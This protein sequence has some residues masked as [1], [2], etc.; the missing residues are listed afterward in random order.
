MKM[1]ICGDLVPTATTEP[2]FIKGDREALFGSVLD[3]FSNADRV[4]VNLECALTDTNTPIPK[5]GPNLKA[6]PKCAE[7]LKNV[8]VTDCMLS[9]NHIFDFGSQGLSDTLDILNKNGLQWTGVGK[10]E[11][12]A[13]KNHIIMAGDKVITIINVCE[14]E[15]T[16]ALPNR[17]GARAYDPYDTMDDIRRAKKNSDY[18]FVIYHGGKEHC[19]YPSPRLRKLCR[20]MVDNGA[21]FVT[22]QHSHCVG[23]YEEYSGSHIIYG[24]GNFHFV[25]YLDNPMWST[26]LMVEIEIGN[27]LDVKFIPVVTTDTGITLADENKKNEILDGFHKRS[28]ELHNGQWLKRWNEFC[29]V[30]RENYTNPIKNAWLEGSTERQN[31]HFAHYLDCEAHTDVWRELFKT[32]NH[33]NL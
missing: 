19:E 7:V 24:Q 11:Q 4:L 23:C 5:C 26:G 32:W 28:E 29:E 25:K 17:A 3:I 33:T 8:G 9:N 30:N 14:H 13:R 20:A 12:D 22:C 6:S 15:Y 16:Y 31:E 1:I 2:Y 10:N 27:K 21:D 18:V